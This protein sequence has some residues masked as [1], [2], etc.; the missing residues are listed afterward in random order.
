MQMLEVGRKT[1]SPL[2]LHLRS[3][4]PRRQCVH[5]P[6]R[7]AWH[8]QPIEITVGDK[9]YFDYGKGWR[10]SRVVPLIDGIKSDRRIK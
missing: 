1:K 7:L 2:T 9:V 10:F 4:R 6:V 5:I 8:M 3:I